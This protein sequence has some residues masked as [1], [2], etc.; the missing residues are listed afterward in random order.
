V[1]DNKRIVRSIEE[2]WDRNDLAALDQY[3]APDFDNSQSATPGV[4][5]GLAGSKMAHQG[6]MAAFPDRKAT[7]LDVLGDGDEVVVRTR[8]TGTNTGGAPFLGAPEPNGAKI[9]FEM[10]SLYRLRDGKVVAH[11]GINDG[12]KGMMQVGS[13]TPP[14]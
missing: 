3:F 9:D 6:V 10:W 12:L 11:A 1:A 8:V 2:A 13:L 5:P 4:P 14:M 7:I